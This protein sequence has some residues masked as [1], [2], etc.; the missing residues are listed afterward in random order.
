MRNHKFRMFA[1]SAVPCFLVIFAPA[2]FLPDL[3]KE[4][5]C[6]DQEIYIAI[7]AI[8]IGHLIGGLLPGILERIFRFDL[9]NMYSSVL[10][11]GAG[12]SVP[13]IVVKSFETFLVLAVLLGIVAGRY[14]LTTK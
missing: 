1:L 13:F 10:L 7:M 2:T 11:L 14:Y 6:T 4:V 12:S 5:K 3:M 9:M 8:G